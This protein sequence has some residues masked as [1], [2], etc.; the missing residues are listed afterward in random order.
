LQNIVSFIGL[1][2]RR[3]LQFQGAYYSKPPHIHMCGP[4]MCHS[5][6]YIFFFWA[7]LAWHTYEI[8]H[9]R[10]MTHLCDISMCDQ[11]MC[12]SYVVFP[13]LAWRTYESCLTYKW[14]I[15]ESCRTCKMNHVAHIHESCRKYEWVMLYI[16][17]LAK[18]F[19]LSY[20]PPINQFFFR[21]THLGFSHVVRMNKSWYTYGWV[22]SHIW[23]SHVAYIWMSYLV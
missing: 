20:N 21:R 19:F 22:M 23:M 16:W 2:C 11:Q 5:Y 8:I 13:F 15:N 14:H 17:S 1:F 12:N 4:Q 6:I 9:M 18:I 10:D 3:G 7:S